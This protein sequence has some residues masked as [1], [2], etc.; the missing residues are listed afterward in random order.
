MFREPSL[1]PRRAQ[2]L[3]G[4][5]PGMRLPAVV[6]LSC[7]LLAR[8]APAGSRRCGDDVDGRGTAVPCDCGDVLV[9]S[10]TLGDDDPI[11]SRVCPGDGLLVRIP[12]GAEG[13]LALSGHVIAG[14]S[15]GVDIQVLQGGEHGFT[16]TGPGIVSGFDT[17][18]P[19]K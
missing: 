7:L 10:R 18:T 8:S 14:S 19:A 4:C 3:L 5:H 12:R 15:H 13:V 11:T 9:G 1:L 17:H 6:A 16:I 2:R